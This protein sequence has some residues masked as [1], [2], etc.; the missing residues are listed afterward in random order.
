MTKQKSWGKDWNKAQSLKGVIYSSLFLMLLLFF[1]SYVSAVL[2]D[3]PSYPKI[4][5][6][7]TTG[8]SGL[9]SDLDFTGTSGFSDL[10]DDTGGAG[11]DGNNYTTAIAFTGSSTKTLN[12]ARFGASNLTATFTDNTGT[13]TNNYLSSVTATNGS[14]KVFTFN[15]DGLSPLYVSI[16]DVD[17]VL[18]ETSVDVYVSNNGYLTNTVNTSY[19][20]AS[21]PLNFINNTVNSSYYLTS[22]PAGYITNTVNA[23]YYLAS[24]PNGYITNT[25]NTS[26]YLASNPA[27]YVSDKVNTSYYLASNPSNYITDGN[28]NWDN[29]YG[30]TVINATSITC[31]GNDK[32]SAYNNATGVFTCTTDQ[33]GAG[34]GDN[35]SWNESLGNS[36]YYLR[37]DFDILDYVFTS[38]LDEYATRHSF[39]S[40]QFN[41]TVTYSNVSIKESWLDSLYVRL[42]SI[43]TL[44][45]NW[46]LDKPSYST[47]AQANALYKPVGIETYNSTANGFNKTFA[48]GLYKPL[49]TPIPSITTTTCTGNDKVSGINNATGV[50]TCTTDQTGA[51]GGRTLIN[52][53][54]LAANNSVIFV[55]YT[56]GTYKVIEYEVF[57]NI[58]NAAAV[59]QLRLNG[60]TT[61]NYAWSKLV[62]ATSTT[63]TGATNCSLDTTA[64][65]LRRNFNIQLFD[66]YINQPKMVNYQGG[67]LGATAA[68]APLLL[69]GGCV[70][71]DTT[72]N[73]TSISIIPNT[74]TALFGIGS[75]IKVYGS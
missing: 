30:F 74:G 35:A 34:S 43:V 69:H 14:I 72:S 20:L 62:A 55:N 31:S 49:S 53:S 7:V 47:T 68:A 39:N 27:G 1:T 25:V 71:Y 22:N 13:D 73:I 57:V 48:D 32:I 75:Y 56:K 12:I 37:T 6:V 45:G 2:L 24:N 17:T 16:D 21:N 3:N 4:R 59:I 5:P 9:F 41:S 67:T 46:T 15:R 64:S 23:S 52:S 63:G 19:Y 10:V 51:G 29:N 11:S 38:T 42:S 36:L 18:N 66:E 54:T 60:N 40:T 26:Y 65:Q 44:V 50:V 33:T 70:L 61:A 8:S 28:T 58:T